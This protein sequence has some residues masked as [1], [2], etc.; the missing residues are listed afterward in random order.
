[1]YEYEHV[2]SAVRSTLYLAARILALLLKRL[3]AAGIRI[4]RHKGERLRDPWR[5]RPDGA[6][7]AQR[8]K[9]CISRAG[10]RESPMAQC[11][12]HLWL[13]NGCGQS[14]SVRLAFPENTLLRSLWKRTL[15]APSLPLPAPP[16]PHSHNALSCC[17]VP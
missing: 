3:I 12:N 11:P 1:M 6:A 9:P 8:R 16:A 17:Y 2:V 14:S 5:R 7:S 10:M 15:S 13:G 4:G